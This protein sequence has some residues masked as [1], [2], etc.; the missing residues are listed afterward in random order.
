MASPPKVQWRPISVLSSNKRT[1]TVTINSTG[2][3][4]NVFIG[5]LALLMLLFQGSSAPGYIR[6]GDRVEEQ[7]RD[8]RGDLGSFLEKMR[9]VI[10]DYSSPAQAKGLLAELQDLPPEPGVFGYQMLPEITE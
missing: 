2:N 4:M 8:H 7:L 1:R 3:I 6:A 10:V 9:R 5:S